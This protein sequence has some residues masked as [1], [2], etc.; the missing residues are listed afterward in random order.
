MAASLNRRTSAPNAASRATSGTNFANP[1]Q[2]RGDKNMGYF[3]IVA[4][5]GACWLAFEAV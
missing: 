3:V 5:L 2:R 1:A 4:F